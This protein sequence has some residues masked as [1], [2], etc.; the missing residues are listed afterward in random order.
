VFARDFWIMD[1]LADPQKRLFNSEA[2]EAFIRSECAHPQK[3]MNGT[4][5]ISTDSNGNQK[6]LASPVHGIVFNSPEGKFAISSPDAGQAQWHASAIERDRSALYAALE[7]LYLGLAQQGQ[8]ARQA[9]TAKAID[10]SDATMFLAFAAANLEEMILA[11][12]RLI[13]EKRGSSST[14]RLDGLNNI[15]GRTLGLM[16]SDAAAYFALN[17]PDAAKKYVH[18]VLAARVCAGAGQEEL[19]EIESEIDSDSFGVSFP[20]AGEPNGQP[21]PAGTA[22]VEPN[23]R[24][25]QENE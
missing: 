13:K 4:P 14:V 16:L 22:S 10:R 9:A 24:G 12:V 5:A 6:V 11:A 21:A 19:K 20:I 23:S 7:A 18:K 17:P 1:R 8:N 15:D 2:D 25:N 3:W